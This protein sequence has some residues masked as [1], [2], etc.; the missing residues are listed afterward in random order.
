MRLYRL[1]ELCY[2]SL[3]A[4]LAQLASVTSKF[5]DRKVHGVQEEFRQNQGWVWKCS[6]FVHSRS[7]SWRLRVCSFIIVRRHFCLHLTKTK[8]DLDSSPS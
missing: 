3:L 4:Q 7:L 5:G 1:Q 2:A 6:L 8:F